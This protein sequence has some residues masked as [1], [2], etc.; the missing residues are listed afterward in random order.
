MVY[1]VF[2]WCCFSV[3]DLYMLNNWK[4]VPF[5][6]HF[7]ICDILTRKV[8]ENILNCFYKHLKYIANRG[9]LGPIFL[10]AT[11]LPGATCAPVLGKLLN[12]SGCLVHMLFR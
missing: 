1:V 2:A 5:S 10:F 8:N 6:Y 7:V 3:F 9:H 11:P 4:L 12:S